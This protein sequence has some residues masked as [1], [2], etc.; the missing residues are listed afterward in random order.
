MKF[1]IIKH[2]GKTTP[3][4]GN[5]GRIATEMEQVFGK[6]ILDSLVAILE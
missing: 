1:T 4:Q 5:Y 3:Y 6:L 2:R